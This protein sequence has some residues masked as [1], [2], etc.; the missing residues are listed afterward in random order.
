MDKCVLNCCTA[1]FTVSNVTNSL[2]QMY[3]VNKIKMTFETT[4]TD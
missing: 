2:Y 3:K 1:N 4:K